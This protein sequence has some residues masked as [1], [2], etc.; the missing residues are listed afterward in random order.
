LIVND[1]YQRI[2][3]NFKEA[4][5]LDPDINIIKSFI[6]KGNTS[7][8]IIIWYLN[9]LG[10]DSAHISFWFGRDAEDIVREIQNKNTSDSFSTILKQH[11]FD[12]NEKINEEYNA[13]QDVYIKA[14]NIVGNLRVDHNEI[15]YGVAHYTKKETS[16][17]LLF[18]DSKFRLS[19]IKKAN[20]PQE[21]ETLIKY[22]AD[23][24]SDYEQHRNNSDSQA[25]VSCFTFNHNHLNQFRLYG[26]ENGNECTGLSLVFNGDFFNKQEILINAS[27]EDENIRHTL[28]RCVY[29]DPKSHNII[30]VGQREEYTFYSKGR[31]SEYEKEEKFKPY[32]EKITEVMEKTRKAFSELENVIKNVKNKDW[33]L[34]SNLLINLR[35]LVKHYAFKEEQECRIIRV[36]KIENLD[37][38]II[39]IQKI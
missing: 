29:I 11:Q 2:W 33:A 4:A 7:P 19:S 28:Y 24:N 9:N 26:K 3:D 37:K 23:N 18:N 5:K 15:D 39:L 35:Y 1:E 30:S 16:E 38:K 14:N 12:T 10:Y 20:D 31:Y 36:K 27:D 25:F 22:L 32:K 8:D 34:I 6:S 21:G 17:K 13:Y